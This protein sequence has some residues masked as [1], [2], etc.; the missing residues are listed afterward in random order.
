MKKEEKINIDITIS[1]LLVSWNDNSFGS[2]VAN[3]S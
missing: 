2:A 1:D 3:A